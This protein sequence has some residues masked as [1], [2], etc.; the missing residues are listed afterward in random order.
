MEIGIDAIIN[1]L[2]NHEESDTNTMY[3]STGKIR[4][5]YRQIEQVGAGGTEA[6]G[7]TTTFIPMASSSPADVMYDGVNYGQLLYLYNLLY[8]TNSATESSV[9]RTYN[10]RVFSNSEYIPESLSDMSTASPKYY[11]L[12][13]SIKSSLGNS[14]PTNSWIEITSW[15]NLDDGYLWDITVSQSGWGNQ[16][17]EATYSLNDYD[18]LYTFITSKDSQDDDYYS[19]FTYYRDRH[20]PQSFGFWEIGSIKKYW[21]PANLIN[22][23]LGGYS[24]V[25]TIPF[26]LCSKIEKYNPSTKDVFITA[27]YYNHSGKPNNCIRATFVDVNITC[28]G[29]KKTSG[30]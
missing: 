6:E 18:M 5:T 4:T 26:P 20:L 24:R 28:V 7:T 16:N 22:T 12:D 29:Y 8:T 9:V 3:A 27:G 30:Q 11:A 25:S 14:L 23:D 15:L 13:G 2:F 19:G 21:H 10:T 1:E 17:G